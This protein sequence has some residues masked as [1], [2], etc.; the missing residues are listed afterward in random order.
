MRHEARPLHAP[1]FGTEPGQ[2]PACTAQAFS[3]ASKPITCAC[4]AITA[5]RAASSGIWDTGHHDQDN[6][7]AIKPPRWASPGET[8]PRSAHT[9]R[10]HAPAPA[11]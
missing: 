4:I 3:A 8:G 7:A 6:Q 1:Y 5:S 11:P 2:L 9:L 10:R